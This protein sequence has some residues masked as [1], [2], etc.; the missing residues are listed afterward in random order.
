MNVQSL[1]L[2]KKLCETPGVSGYEESIQKLVA[3]ELRPVVTE[4]KVD[5]LGNVIG[6]RKADKKPGKARPLK[7]MIAAHMDEIGFMV[8]FIDK[9]GFLRLE[10]LGGF[11]PVTL[12]GQ[13]VVVHGKKDVLGVIA[14]RPMWLLEKET[15]RKVPELKELF[16]DLGMPKDKVARLVSVGDVV[17]LAQDFKELNEEV[18]TGRN[19]DDRVGVYV[20]LETMKRLETCYADVYAVSTVQEELGIRG[21]TVASF[22]IEPDIGI[23]IDGSLASDIPD[24]KEEDRHC[25]L[26]KGVGIYL[27]DRLTVS[28]KVLVKCLIELAEKHNIPY[29]LNIG[30]GTDASAIQRTKA[31]A[32]ACTIGPPT[33][34]MHSTVQLC[35]KD[36]IEAAIRLLNVF[37]ENIHELDLGYA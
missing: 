20:M 33:R 9:D 1:E 23:A 35:H 19:F 24:V 28:S 14:P 18:V 29:Q 8:K 30:G 27:V 13:R 12:V 2:L 10:P 26:G 17:S 32:L 36:D 5:K 7:V 11:D 6:Y 37:L 31:G 15:Q 21:A 22:Q 3:D 16:V 25:S 34:Y 4:V